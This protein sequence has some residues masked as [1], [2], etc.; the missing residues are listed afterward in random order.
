MELNAVDGKRLSVT[1][2]DTNNDKL[3]T[4]ADNVDYNGTNTIISGVQQPSLGMVFESPV[5]ISH[6]TRSEGKYQSGTNGG[7]GNVGMLRESSSRF[8][9]RMSW[10]KLR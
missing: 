10:K 7:S 4:S 8:S 9:G 6:N 3:F 1:P 5:I 2:I